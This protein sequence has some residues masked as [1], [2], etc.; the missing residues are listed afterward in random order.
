MKKG[1]KTVSWKEPLVSPKS[2]F[3]L[4]GIFRTLSK[5]Q[6]DPVNPVGKIFL[7]A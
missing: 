7:F 6:I 4:L 3:G 5:K 2:E 1:K